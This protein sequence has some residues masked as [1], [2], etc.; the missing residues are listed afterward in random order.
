MGAGDRDRSLYRALFSLSSMLP[1]R[2]VLRTPCNHTRCHVTS[3]KAT[4]TCR[5]NACLAVTC[6]LHFWQNGRNLVHAIEC[7]GDL[8]FCVRGTPL[9]SRFSPGSMLRSFVRLV[10]RRVVSGEALSETK[11]PGGGGWSGGGCHH[12][13]DSA[14]RWAGLA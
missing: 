12:Q 9:R 2:R 7:K 1:S 10:Q 13:N 4:Y 5:L 14:L 3:C 11:I 8:N 6:H